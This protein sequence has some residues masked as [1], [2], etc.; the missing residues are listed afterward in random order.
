MKK[1]FKLLISLLIPQLAGG[2]GSFF[3]VGSVKDWYPVLVKHSLNPPAWIFGPVWTT[4]FIL[5]GYALYL[6]WKDNSGKSKRLAYSAFGIQMVLNT[7]W[8]IIFFGLHSPGGAFIEIIF[9]LLAILATIIAFYKISKPA[10]WLLVPYITWVSFAMYL[11][12]S[13]YVLN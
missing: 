3:T 4:L 1:T 8:S 10:A 6:V 11:N 9:L 13:I 5:M 12:Y 2:I 7:F